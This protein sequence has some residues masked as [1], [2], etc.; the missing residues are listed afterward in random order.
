MTNNDKTNNGENNGEFDF[1]TLT[2]V[3]NSPW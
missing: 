3:F 1:T 2:I